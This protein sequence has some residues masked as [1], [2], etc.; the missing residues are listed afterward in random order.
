MSPIVVRPYEP[1][2]LEGYSDVRSLTY[3]NGDPVPVEH[4]ERPVSRYV[5]EHDGL[6]KGVFVVLD[7]TCTRG[8]ALMRCGG[9]ASVGVLPHERRTGVGKEMMRSAVRLMREQGT[10]M[11]SLYA[12]RES[13]YRMFGYE[14]TG[15][16]FRIECPVERLPRLAGSLPIRRLRPAQWQ[17]IDPCQRAFA[18]ARSGMSLRTEALWRR[19]LAE[20]RELTMYAAGDPVEAYAVVSHQ[21]GFFQTDHISEIAWSTRRGYESLFEIL[22]S[23]GINK[24]ALTWYEPSDSPFLARFMDQGVEVRLDRPIMFRVCDVPGALRSLKPAFSGSFTVEVEDDL[25]P[26]NRGPWKVDF[27]KGVVT[28]APSAAADLKVDVRQFAQAFL[29][30][31]SWSDLARDGMVAVKHGEALEAAMRLMPPTPVYC[32]EFF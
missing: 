32:T 22:R 23:I 5:A 8:E 16:R 25:V 12:F 2:D 7:F 4:M 30:E 19:V 15:R 24:T 6:I 9:V 11:A 21:V 31:P 26:E 20:N 28:V 17:E 27:E 10:P 14:V 13:Y 3:Y 29:G 1:R 18:H